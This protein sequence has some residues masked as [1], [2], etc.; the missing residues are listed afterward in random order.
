ML[1]LKLD[2]LNEIYDGV[3][4]LYD[5][6][7]HINKTVS[8]VLLL[9]YETSSV[10]IRL[11]VMSDL[12]NHK[13][14]SPIYMGDCILIDKIEGCA[15]LLKTM[16]SVLFQ[17]IADNDLI[18]VVSLSTINSLKLNKNIKYSIQLV[19]HDITY[20]VLKTN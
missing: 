18:S 10:Q 17:A 9:L 16:L 11:C 8:P 12:I 19:E 6:C 7:S 1:E 3:E 15:S 14:V 4:W 2:N 20:A 13:F 5:D